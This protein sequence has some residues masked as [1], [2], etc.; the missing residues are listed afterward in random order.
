MC[1]PFTD[2]L[3]LQYIIIDLT[4]ID[5]RR[6]KCSSFHLYVHYLF[7]SDSSLGSL[8]TSF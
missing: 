4:I 1:D 5:L 3:G 7:I 2:T 6:R 8:T